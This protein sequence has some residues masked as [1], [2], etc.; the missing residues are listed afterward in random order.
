[1]T[2]N[3]RERDTLIKAVDILYK[4]AD[5]TDS[6]WESDRLTTLAEKVELIVTNDEDEDESAIAMRESLGTNWW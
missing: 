5:R 2:I 3:Q 1:M 4:L 6:R